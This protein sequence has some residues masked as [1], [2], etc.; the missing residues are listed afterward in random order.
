MTCQLRLSTSQIQ[1]CSW[2]CCVFTRCT[3][4]SIHFTPTELCANPL[5]FLFEAKFL[6]HKSNVNVALCTKT[7][8]LVHTN[9][10]IDGARWSVQVTL[11]VKSNT[12]CFGRL[13]SACCY[14]SVGRKKEWGI[15]GWY[16]MSS[17]TT[18]TR[19][20][21]LRANSLI[22]FH[23][24]ESLWLHNNGWSEKSRRDW[25]A[26]RDYN[27]KEIWASTPSWIFQVQAFKFVWLRPEPQNLSAADDRD[28]CHFVVVW[29]DFL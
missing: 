9:L 11:Q 5:H 10:G 26:P 20:S 18:P 27:A 12:F 29:A 25:K 28:P 16:L 1:A 24:C 3:I 15:L 8:F 13:D 22:K 2:C 23:W 4:S 14:W 6:I 19:P 21:G 7:S 17:N